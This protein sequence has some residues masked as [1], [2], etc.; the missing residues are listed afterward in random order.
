MRHFI[1]SADRFNHILL[2]V[3]MPT[4]SRDLLCRLPL[5]RQEQ[6]K[7]EYE[8][9]RK[10]HI[11]SCCERVVP[12]IIADAEAYKGSSLIPM[13]NFPKDDSLTKEEVIEGFKRIFPDCTITYN[14]HH[15]SPDEQ[16]GNILI[17]WR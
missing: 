4:Y 17:A 12:S 6:K 9:K 7:K 11:Y 1:H 13:S 2:D 15:S 3:N 10:R 5:I 14:A 16:H 8:E